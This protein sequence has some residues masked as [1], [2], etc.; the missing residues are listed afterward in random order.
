MGIPNAMKIGLCRLL[1][2]Y[3]DWPN[4]AFNSEHL[5]FKPEDILNSI[6]R[7]IRNVD[8]E[9]SRTLTA[10]LIPCFLLLYFLFIANYPETILPEIPALIYSMT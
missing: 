4:F 3:R 7:R 5:I 9:A 8:Y 1:Q 2:T 6:L 10:L